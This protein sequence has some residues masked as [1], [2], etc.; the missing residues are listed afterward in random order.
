VV[1]A[2]LELSLKVFSQADVGRSWC[3]APRT[4]A[5]GTVT[6]SG[7]PRCR[8]DRRSDLYAMAKQIRMKCIHTVVE[9]PDEV[10]T[11]SCGASG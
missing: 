8:R 9:R 1:S 2:P 7:Q 6:M 10:Y 11:H 4:P 5:H 3:K